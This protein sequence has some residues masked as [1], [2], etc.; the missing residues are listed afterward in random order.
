V[1]D[2]AM[3]QL[4]K[5]KASTTHDRPLPGSL[6]LES[7]EQLAGLGATLGLPAAAGEHLANTFGMRAAAVAKRIQA[8][9]AC[10][11]PLDPEMPYL[12]AQVDEAVEHEFARTLD[13]VLTRRIPLVLRGRDQGLGIAPKVA[14]RLQQKLGW[15]DAMTAAELAHYR[16]VVEA[17]RK[18]R[19]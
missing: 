13:D 10:A 11:E 7:D 17:S 4:G 9:P 15:S 5:E 18:F 1:V 2:K 12:T 14:A 3:E 8:D 16:S 19:A 6:G